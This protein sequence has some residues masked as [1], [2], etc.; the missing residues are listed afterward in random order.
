MK[1]AITVAFTMEEKD[2]ER[3]EK[4][5]ELVKTT[6]STFCREII[7]KTLNDLDT[8]MAVPD[9]A[10]TDNDEPDTGNDNLF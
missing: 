7:V 1:Q 4:Y 6:K 5:V 9:I 8:S 10:V 3:L 2:Y